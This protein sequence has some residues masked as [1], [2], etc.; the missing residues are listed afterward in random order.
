MTI[1]PELAKVS[2]DS[3]LDRYAWELIAH[4]NPTLAFSIFRAVARSEAPYAS[5]L[6]SALP[7]WIVEMIEMAAT[8]VQNNH[9]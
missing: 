9:P 6:S 4:L 1:P 2:D 5:A 8:H 7:A 3:D